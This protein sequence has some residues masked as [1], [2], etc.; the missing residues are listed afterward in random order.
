[1]TDDLLTRTFD[2]H[3][4]DVKGDGRTLTLALVPFMQ[5]AE[6]WDPNGAHYRE[7][8]ARGAFSNVV[9]APNRVELR[10]WH[11]QTGLPYGFG[12][13]LVED[14]RYLVGDFRVS[15]SVTGDHLLALVEDGLKGVSVGFYADDSG[16]VR[17]GDLVTRTRVKRVKEVSMTPAP[18]YEG[19]EVLAVRAQEPR[20]GPSRVEVARERERAFWS[21]L[22]A[23]GSV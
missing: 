15:R 9:R 10:Y 18:A 7:Q 16:A 21:R 8:F 6:V 2:L 4:V 23:P 19:A 17:E 1:M 12:S 5:P 22:A 13:R 11:D 20:S 3:D 14:D